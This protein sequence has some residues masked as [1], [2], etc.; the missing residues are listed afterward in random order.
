MPRLLVDEEASN[1]NV[2]SKPS[3][4]SGDP[5]GKPVSVRDFGAKG[6]GR[7]DDTA[8]LQAALASGARILRVPDGTYPIRNV[9]QPLTGQTLIVEGTLKIADTEIQPLTADVAVGDGVVEV[10]DA[11]GFR[12]GEWVTL[13]DDRL[14]IQGGG[15]KIRRQNAGNARITAI[16]GNRIRLDA[17]SARAY[18]REAGAV[19]GRQHTALLIE[20]S[21]V[22]IGGF[23]TIDGN[24][25]NQ[26]NAAPS[27]LE[28]VVGEDGRVGSCLKVNGATGKRLRD[29][30]IETLTLRDAVLHNLSMGG[31]VQSVVRNV[32]C[33]GAHDKNLSL[34]RCLD[35][36]LLNNRCDDSEWEDG[37]VFHQTDAPRNGNRRIR[38][39][40][41]LCSGNARNGIHIGGNMREITLVGN[42]CAH[43]GLNMT[44]DGDSGSSTD[45]V[46]IGSN[47]RL[48][49]LDASRP[50]LRITG[51]GVRV[52][53]LTAHGTPS[54]GV[55]VSGREVSL[56]ACR[57]GGLEPPWSSGDGIGVVLRPGPHRGGQRTPD[58]FR[59]SHCRIWGCRVGIDL[60]PAAGSIRLED[61][62]F[63]GNDRD[64]SPEAKRHARPDLVGDGAT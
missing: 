62:D 20:H 24:K 41:N 45:D 61:N 33:L 3:L 16:D 31:A 59:M 7:H 37:I 54:W 34:S 23:G 63:R 8:A 30:V 64:L 27:R 58:R 15:R 42:L 38:L 49:P 19:L 5:G 9:L 1:V 13:H 52:N 40:G 6:D 22:R 43:N 32:V 36:L 56:E 60:D 10:R 50:N 2:L 29:V 55:E 46:L 14:P 28:D 39:E 53:R 11:L 57:I 51:N 4:H 44:L 12:V 25:R 35:C 26:L 17:R 47:G 48:F 21:N 18:L